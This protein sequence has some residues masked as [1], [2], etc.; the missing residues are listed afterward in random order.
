MEGFIYITDIKEIGNFQEDLLLS[1]S[2]GFD[3]ETTGLDHFKDIITLIQIKINNKIYIFDTQKLGNRLATYILDL[4]EASDKVVIGHNLSFDVRFI[5]N[6]YGVLFT[7][8]YDTMLAEMLI[9]NGRGTSKYPSLATLVSKYFVVDLN[10]SIR[11]QFYGN[12]EITQEMLIYAMEDVV[13]LDG[14]KKFQEVEIVKSGQEKVL[15]LE[16]KVL[17]VIAEMELNGITVNVEKWKDVVMQTEIIANNL[18]ENLINTIVNDAINT[19]K[20]SNA[21]ELVTLMGMLQKNTSQ[22][23]QDTLR[24]ITDASFIIKYLKEN[25]NINSSKQVLSILT[26]I[27]DIK[28]E[29]TNEKSINKLVKKHPIIN[30]L[31]TY[32]GFEKELSS[33]STGYL[34]KIRPETRRLHTTYNQLG[35]VTGRFSSQNPNM[36]NV[37]GVDKDEIGE[38]VSKYR[39]CFE[40]GNGKM[41]ICADYSQQELRLT[42]EITKDKKMLETFINDL[43]PHKM[44]ASGLFNVPYDK[45]TKEQR[46]KGKSLNFAVNYGSSEYGLERNFDIPLAD[47]RKYIE[48]YFRFYS[49]YADFVSKVS[50]KIWQ[51]GY[52]TTM[53]GRKRYFDKPVIFKDGY[54]A[55]KFKART[56]RSLINHIVQGSGADM[57]KLALVNIFYN[58]P[59]G[60]KLK[61]LLQVHDEIVLECTEDIGNEACEFVKQ[62][63][64]KAEGEFI[65]SIKCKVDVNYSK[66]WEH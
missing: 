27:Y 31:I 56:T 23:V 46:K 29:N 1:D 34:D 26:N 5:K 61:I 53:L 14:I 24:Q 50:S 21:L 47:G 41:L 9:T 11:E 35:A 37:K 16:M 33:F 13:Y 58:N 3:I 60:D 52:S 15:D 40:A 7:K 36:Q 2:I 59:F 30:Q 28:V 48:E 6:K 49:G 57:T 12:T 43:D 8:V 64:L 44:T 65:K 38:E 22:K 20:Y 51:I 18:R 42:A 17:P 66:I 39:P 62:Q 25:I 32:R 54:E 45:V 19:G 63:M 55:S 10:K 4:I